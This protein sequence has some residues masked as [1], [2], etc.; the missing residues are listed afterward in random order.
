[1]SDIVYGDWKWCE[2]CEHRK[3][4]VRKGSD[5]V[6]MGIDWCGKC[7]WEENHVYPSMVYRHSFRLGGWCPYYAEA[8]V[9]QLNNGK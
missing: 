5:G 4:S 7:P 2:G 3:I 6:L 8:M 1:M 9:E